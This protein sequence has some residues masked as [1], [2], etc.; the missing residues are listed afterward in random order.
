MDRNRP[1]ELGGAESVRYSLGMDRAPLP[2]P[3]LALAAKTIWW[4]Q[5]EE[6]LADPHR[7]LAQIMALGTWEDV[8]LAKQHWSLD[9]FRAVLKAPP[10]GVFDGRS[11]QYWHCVLR[12][13]PI[14]DLP[15]RR[16]P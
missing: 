16:L 3:L 15:V 5:P 6:A 2:E 4:K 12:L 7:L 11:W 10:P 9:D 13:T 14:P 1:A 8:Q